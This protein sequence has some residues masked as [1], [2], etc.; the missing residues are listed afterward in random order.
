MNTHRLRVLLVRSIVAAVFALGMG[1]CT[2]TM[3]L[4]AAGTPDGSDVRTPNDAGDAQPDL[5]PDLRPDSAPDVVADAAPDVVADAVVPDD[6]HVD[7]SV[8]VT[9]GMNCVDNGITYHSGDVVLRP[10]CRLSCI[11]V[12]GVVGACSG[13]PCPGDGSV[14]ID[15]VPVASITQSAAGSSPEVDVHIDNLGEAQR[16]IVGAPDSTTPLPRSFPPGAPEVTLFLYH[17]QNVGDL[18]KVGGAACPSSVGT[19]KVTL[20][21]P[22]NVTSGNLKCLGNASAVEIAL[23]QDVDVLL[24]ITDTDSS[25]NARACETTGGEISN[26][27]CCTGSGNFPDTC[28]IGACSCAPTSVHVVDTCLCPTGGCFEKS[29][30]CVGPASVCTVGDDQSCNDNPGANAF[31]GR[32]VTGGHCLCNTGFTVVAAS[33]R[34]S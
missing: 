23:A 32:C 19:I 13:I 5:P 18:S 8:D 9:P 3:S 17:L 28:A 14:I 33:G 11:C 22:S 12:D 7:Q 6:G 15:P 16:T 4:G 25:I 21:A 1:A 31:H 24:G 20:A 29:V 34:C 2:R 30:G 27:L 26:G 10:G